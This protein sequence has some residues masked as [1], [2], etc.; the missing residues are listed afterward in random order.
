MDS[1]AEAGE[2]PDSQK[3]DLPPGKYKVTLKVDASAPQSREFEVA[4][5]ET[6]GLL[7]GPD[8]AALPI[9]LY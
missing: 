2:L 1:D 7:V 6:W 3:L 5:D 4:A 9:R 8:G